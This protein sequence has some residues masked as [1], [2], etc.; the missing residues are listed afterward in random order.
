[1]ANVR[2]YAIIYVALVTLAI[3]KF[4]FFE[5]LAYGLALTLTMVAASIKTGLI[6]AYF[7]HLR[8]EPRI[9]SVLMFTALLGVVTLAAAASL[10]IL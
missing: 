1:M 8:Y 4:V 7:Q 3:S 10:S 6:V 5:F 2:W 9:L